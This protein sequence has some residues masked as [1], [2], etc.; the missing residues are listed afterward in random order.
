LIIQLQHHVL[1]AECSIA[2]L[3]SVMSQAEKTP[4]FFFEKAQTWQLL[5]SLGFYWV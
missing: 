3:M 2:V 5:L 4:K 1:S